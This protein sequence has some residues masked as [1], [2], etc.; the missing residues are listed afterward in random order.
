MLLSMQRA[1]INNRWAKVVPTHYIIDKRWTIVQ[2]NKL[3]VNVGAVRKDKY[4]TWWQVMNANLYGIHVELVGNFNKHKPSDEQY[5]SLY[6][7]V[8]EL[9]RVK[10]YDIAYHQTFQSKEC[11]GKLFNRERFESLF[12]GN[13]AIPKDLVF[14][15]TRYYSPV[16]WQSRYYMNK[17]YR[18]DVTMNCGADAIW[19]DGCL[20]PAM[21][22]IKLD[23]S[24]K[25]WYVACPWK[26][27]L[28][29]KFELEGIGTV[30]CVDRWWAIQMKGHVVRLDMYCWV[31]EYALDNWD[32]CITWIYKGKVVK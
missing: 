27:P 23:M 8:K 31:G 21:K 28:G 29:T 14:S 2:V 9:R 30:T 15:L 3:D 32:T 19:N 24:H 12:L 13:D 10:H 7:L 17:S 5:A 1:W 26:Y 20:Y 11:P 16:M 22:G 6:R 4:N 18:A 25:N